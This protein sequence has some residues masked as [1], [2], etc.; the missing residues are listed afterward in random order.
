MQQVVDIL[1]ANEGKEE[2][3]DASQLLLL[4]KKTI[5]KFLNQVQF[6]QI[7]RLL[8]KLSSQ[9]MITQK[10]RAMKLMQL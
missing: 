7:A 5:K 4:E 2:L 6:Y 1:A 9:L 3:A 10:K 8:A